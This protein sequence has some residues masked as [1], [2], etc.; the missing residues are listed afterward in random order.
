ME[1]PLKEYVK[2]PAKNVM[3]PAMARGRHV[4]VEKRMK[5]LAEFAEF[6]DL[7]RTEYYDTSI[8]IIASGA[9]YQYAKEALGENASYLKLGMVN[10]LPVKLIEDFAAKCDKV[11]V[12]E[13]LDDI[14]ETHCRKF[15]ISVIGK[16]LF[17]LTGELS[18]AIVAEKIL[19]EEKQTLSL[20]DEIPVRPPVMCCGCPHRGLFYALKRENVFVSGDIGCYTLGSQPPP[21]RH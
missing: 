18:Q 9:S 12:V 20:K 16:E 19:G 2:N 11:Y 15:G 8:G 4:F 17:P 1:P 21:L 13:E 14:I 5:A 7:N 3:M 6:C 10:P